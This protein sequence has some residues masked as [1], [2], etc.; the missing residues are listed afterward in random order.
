MKRSFLCWFVGLAVLC[1]RDFCPAL[2]ALFGPVKI[3]FFPHFFTS[4]GP[5][6]GDHKEMS[7]ILADQYRPS[8]SPNA[9]GGGQGLGRGCGVSVNE[10]SCAH[11]TQINFGDLTPYLTYD[12]SPSPS[13]LGMQSYRVSCVSLV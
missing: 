4:C 2:A 3:L 7:S 10:H 1:T 11:G 9:G 5:P 13:K 6:P 8:T 12:L